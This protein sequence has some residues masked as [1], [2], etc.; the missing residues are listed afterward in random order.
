MLLLF[1]FLLVSSPFLCLLCLL[2][3]RPCLS[4]AFPPG[5]L[6]FPASPNLGSHFDFALRSSIRWINLLSIIVV[7]ICHAM[8]AFYLSVTRQCSPSRYTIFSLLIYTVPFRRT[9]DRTQTPS[10]RVGTTSTRLC[11]QPSLFHPTRPTVSLTIV[12]DNTSTICSYS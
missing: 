4:S 5:H 9:C 1:S 10:R 12:S 3:Q 6:L 2:P 8:L 7:Y 11:Q